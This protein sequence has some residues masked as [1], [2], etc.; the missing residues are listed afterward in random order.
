MRRRDLRRRLPQ[1]AVR[2]V[3][4][5]I[6]HD[7]SERDARADRQPVAVRDLAQGGDVAKTNE[8]V[9]HLLPALHVGSRSVPPANRRLPVGMCRW[10][11]DVCGAW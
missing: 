6:A 3:H 8:C 7:F 9:G 4:A 5:R 11:P 1:A 2:A 10:L